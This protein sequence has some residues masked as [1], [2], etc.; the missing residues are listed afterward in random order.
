MG[1]F[2]E[3]ADTKTVSKTETEATISDLS[4]DTT[5]II[6]VQGYSAGGAGVSSDPNTVTTGEW[7]RLVG[8][9]RVTFGLSGVQCSE[10][11]GEQ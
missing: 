4:A 9:I 11:V 2:E 6:T 8:G 10:A 3:D 5:Y 1:V 7:R